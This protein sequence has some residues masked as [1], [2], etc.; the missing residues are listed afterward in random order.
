MNVKITMLYST[1]QVEL[2]KTTLYK[3][4]FDIMSIKRH[5]FILRGSG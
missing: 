3:N 2:K 5:N 1:V 4:N